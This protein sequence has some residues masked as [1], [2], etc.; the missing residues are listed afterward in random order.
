MTP[1]NGQHAQATG[2]YHPRRPLWL[3]ALHR[4]GQVWQRLGL[5][6]AQLNADQLLEAAR[7]RTG[8]DDFGAIPV[9]EP[10]QLLLHSCAHEARLTAVGRLAVAQ[11]AVQLLS[12]RLA[13]EEDWKRRPGIA[14][15]AIVRP[16]FTVG[17]PRTGTSLLQGLLAQDPAHRTPLTWEVMYP[18]PPPGRRAG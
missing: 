4:G 18:S 9:R 13:L 10:L 8:L 2:H 17:L 16:L 11:D 5:P 6:L 12:T 14:A 3:R 7:Q 1:S 15:K